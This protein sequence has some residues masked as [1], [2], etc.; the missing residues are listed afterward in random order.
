MSQRPRNGDTKICLICGKTAIF[1]DRQERPGSR[2]SPG[3][4]LPETN[5]VPAWRCEDPKCDY[6]EEL[7]T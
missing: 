4:T 5:A 1:K 2:A 3:S 6:F 7:Q